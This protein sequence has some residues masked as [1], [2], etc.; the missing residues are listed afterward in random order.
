MSRQQ[1]PRWRSAGDSWLL[2]RVRLLSEMRH[3]PQQCPLLVLQAGRQR[4]GLL[5]LKEAQRP[6]GSRWCSCRSTPQRCLR[7]WQLP[8]NGICMRALMLHRLGERHREAGQ[9]AGTLPLTSALWLQIVMTTMARQHPLQSSHKLLMPQ[10]HQQPHTRPP[11]QRFRAQ[12]P[13]PRLQALLLLGCRIAVMFHCNLLA[14][15]ALPADHTLQ[16]QWLT[17]AV[18]ALAARRMQMCSRCALLQ[19]QWRQQPLLQLRQRPSGFRSRTPA[20][21]VPLQLIT[22]LRRFLVAVAEV[23]MR[24]VRAVAWH[25]CCSVQCGRGLQ[26]R[27]AAV[28]LQRIAQQRRRRSRR[29]CRVDCSE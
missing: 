26:C 19:L 15:L 5:P 20:L 25:S 22:H 10:R 2:H 17:V 29:R 3:C 11:Q 1:L 7:H 4:T 13:S 24:W 18:P 27:A 21:M 23:R 16:I 9:E 8:V 12:L 6:C 28:G 14:Q